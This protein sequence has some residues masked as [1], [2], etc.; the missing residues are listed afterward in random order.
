MARASASVPAGVL[1]FEMVVPNLLANPSLTRKRASRVGRARLQAASWVPT[2][3]TRATGTVQI[4]RCETLQVSRW[5]GAH[6]PGKGTPMTRTVRRLA[7]V[8][9]LAGGVALVGAGCRSE[10]GKGPAETAGKKIDDAAKATG[11]AMKDAAGATAGAAKDAAAGAANIAKD[12]ADATRDAA[13]DAAAGARDAGRATADAARDA[14]AGAKDVAKDAAA[15]TKDA[16]K[17][18]AA[19]AADAA[20][21][22]GRALDKAADAAR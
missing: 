3:R 22:A 13:H 8:L 14:A 5:A 1:R 15:G 7:T 4:A 12:A 18:T 2:A 11:D 21:D 20:H 10:T 17:D 19:A 16:A 6:G 9:V